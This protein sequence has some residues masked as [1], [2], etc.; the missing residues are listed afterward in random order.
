MET[1]SIT[2]YTAKELREQ[3]P[4][5]YERA[6]NRFIE[7]HWGWMIQEYIGDALRDVEADDNS[8]LG[9]RFIEWDANRGWAHYA[10]GDLTATERGAIRLRFPGLDAASQM[11]IDAGAFSAAFYGDDEDEEAFEGAVDEVNEFLGSLYARFR[12]A[13]RQEYDHIMSEEY[14]L[15]TC[16]AN[17]LTFESDGDMRNV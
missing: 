10:D 6:H 2:V 15:D 12:M 17:G 5:G 8:P 4:V 13:M 11:G 1:I 9:G 14:F 7:D 16:E 3:Y